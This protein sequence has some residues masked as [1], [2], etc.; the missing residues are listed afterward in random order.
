VTNPALE[1]HCCQ[2]VLMQLGA[3]VLLML[4]ALAVLASDAQL[5][6]YGVGRAPTA[7]EIAAWDLTIPPDGEGLPAGSGTA[8]LGKSIYTRR[9]ASCHGDDGKDPKYYVLVGGRGTLATD[10]P[11]VTVGSFWQYATTLWS[12]MRRSKPIDEPGSFNA[13]QVYA[14]TAYM[15]FLN[16][17]IGEHDILDATTLVQ[18]R[19]PNGDGYVPDPRPDVENASASVI[20]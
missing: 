11:V 19:M 14:V 7:E 13:D 6:T 3:V 9:C 20:Q 12:Y 17:I 18:I 10:K 8:V 5:P 4:T 16:D 15:L 1:S 2:R